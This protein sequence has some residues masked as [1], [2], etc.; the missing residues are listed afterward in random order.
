MKLLVCG[1]RD[2]NEVEV[3]DQLASWIIGFES[4]SNWFV[5]EIIQGRATG[6]D[7][8]AYNYAIDHGLVTQS[9]FPHW[10]RFG[11]AAGMIR[12]KKMLTEGQPDAILAFPGGKGTKGMIK[13]AENAGIPVYKIGDWND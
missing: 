7:T 1:G 10:E 9:Y 6:A 5:T 8:A 4:S 2:L 3:Y 11:N 12:N 13:L